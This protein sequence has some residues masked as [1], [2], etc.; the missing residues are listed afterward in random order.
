MKIILL[1][2]I[3]KLGKRGEVKEVADG[4]ALN[5]LIKK[6][7]ALQ[8]TPNELAMWKAKADSLKHKKE[9]ATNKFLQ[10]A[11]VL[12]KTEL[13]ITGKKSDNKGQLFAQVKEVDI[14]DAI[15]SST[16]V[17]IDPKQVEIPTHIKST[18]KHQFFLKQGAEKAGFTILVQ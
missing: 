17:S 2:D 1:K 18:G 6:G 3:A 4:Y 14:T 15:F 8:A 10:L 13:L 7:D 11:D 12:K 9:I 16:A 5:V